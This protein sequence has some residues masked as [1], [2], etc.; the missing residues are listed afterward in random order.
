MAIVTAISEYDI[1]Q[2]EKDKLQYESEVEQARY[3]AELEHYQRSEEVMM[4]QFND[5]L[6]S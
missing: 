6:L 2:H 3:E 4:K 1:E 5:Y